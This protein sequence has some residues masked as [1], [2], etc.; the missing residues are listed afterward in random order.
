ML[1]AIY[2]EFL[3]VD[4]KHSTVEITL[5]PQ[6]GD[7]GLAMV[8]ASLLLI[9]HDKYPA[10]Q[11]P[12]LRLING[13]GLSD[14]SLHDIE[15]S[16]L[17]TAESL[18]GTNCVFQIVEEARD[19]ITSMNEQGAECEIC[20]GRIDQTVQHAKSMDT[21]TG[22]VGFV[23]QC[24]HVFHQGCFARW[25]WEYDQRMNQSSERQSQVHVANS[26]ITAAINSVNQFRETIEKLE[27]QIEDDTKRLNDLEDQ[28]KQISQEM[29]EMQQMP[30]SKR[31]NAEDK[32]Y[33]QKREVSVPNPSLFY[34]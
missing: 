11:A 5:I 25:M 12:Q 29:E 32:L 15:H 19:H 34:F 28:Y 16:L 33:K 26:R 18:S 27:Q 7:E 9:F 24:L 1:E 3:S 31:K 8:R 17:E 10:D 2:P 22:E 21:Y 6:T 20:Y 23:T 14:S 4:H 30:N 13:R